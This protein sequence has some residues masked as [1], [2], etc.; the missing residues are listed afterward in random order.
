MNIKLI[1]KY[2]PKLTLVLPKS[3]GSVRDPVLARI[4]GCLTGIDSNR[5][6]SEKV[7][8]NNV[9]WTTSCDVTRWIRLLGRLFSSQMSDAG[10]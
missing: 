5:L 6:E 4:D 3:A 7:L 8:C 2:S 1:K 9:L 10:R